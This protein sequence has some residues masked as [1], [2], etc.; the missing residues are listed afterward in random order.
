MTN[1]AGYVL[2]FAKKTVKAI[3]PIRAI[4]FI[5]S[6][7]PIVLFAQ[8]KE[9][10]KVSESIP[11]PQSFVSNHRGIFGGITVEYAVTAG[12]TYLKDNNGKPVASIWSVAYTRTNPQNKLQRPVTF[13]FNGGPGSASVWLHMGLFGPKIAKVPSE[14]DADDGAA[15][16][17]IIANPYTFLDITDIVFIDPVGT[18]YS[19]VIGEGK[20]EDFWGLNEDARSVAQFIRLWITENKRWNAPKFIAGESFGTTRAAGV[21]NEL[22]GSGQNVA[23]NGLILISQALD[24]TGS[25]PVPDNLVAFITYLPTMASTAWYH[26]KAGAGKTLETFVEEARNFAYD[27]YAPALLRGNT[28][29]DTQRNRIAERLAYFTGLDKNYILRSD[30][31]VLAT[32]FRKELLRAE[33]LTVGGLDT[34]YVAEE[35]DQVAERPTLGDAASFSV[36]SAYTAA[37]QD[38]FAND[39]QINMDRPYFTSAQ[40]LYSKW[41]WAESKG[42]E[43]H[44]VNV[45]RK[46]SDV[47]RRNSDLKV[48]VANGYYDMV[49]PFFDAEYTLTRHGIK[50][51]RIDMKYYEAGH[52][53]YTHEADLKKLAADIRAFYLTA[54]K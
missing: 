37:L 23:L 8:D 14:A 22:E 54:L 10:P 46:L 30:L 42:Q 38:Y 4:L 25:T 39:L 43:P 6:L 21:A 36:T 49:T 31:R 13:V 45:T 27:E 9:K 7:F 41:N 53:M 44:Y 18:G 50:G 32:R 19:K 2:S 48:M 15:P 5:I 16:Y 52:M 35:P 29:S 28:L 24:Y 26:K 34:R 11:E 33:G 1:S 20:E 17:P 3:H 47:L 12:E 51:D 40:G